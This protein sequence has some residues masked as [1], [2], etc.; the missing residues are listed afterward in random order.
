MTRTFFLIGLILKDDMNNVFYWSIFIGR[1]SWK[2]M[3]RPQMMN[4]MSG[5]SC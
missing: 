5:T 3:K 4:Q 1:R 2:K